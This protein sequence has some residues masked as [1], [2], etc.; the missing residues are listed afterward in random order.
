MKELSYLPLNYKGDIK[1]FDNKTDYLK[2]NNEKFSN[3]INNYF[4]KNKRKYFITKDLTIIIY[5]KT[6][7]LMVI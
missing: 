5:L 2:K 3:F 7:E 6:Y 1:F 4:I